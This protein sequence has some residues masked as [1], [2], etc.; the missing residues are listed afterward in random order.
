V[1]AVDASG[2]PPI[3]AATS[4]T[5]STV[6]PAG[7]GDAGPTSSGHSGGGAVR[8]V[9]GAGAVSSSITGGGGAGAC[10]G[11]DPA[12]RAS[13]AASRRASSCSSLRSIASRTSGGIHSQRVSG[14]STKSKHMLGKTS[15][16]LKKKHS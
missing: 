3:S 5:G 2:R 9:S 15:N 13:S 1:R 10:S 12:S 7:H 16:Q 8:R 4:R 11:V 6:A 14:D